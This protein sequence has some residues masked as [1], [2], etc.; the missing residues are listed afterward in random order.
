S[1]KTRVRRLR[2]YQVEA[3]ERLVAEPAGSSWPSGHPAVAAA[4]L[5]ALAPQ[6]PRATRTAGGVIAGFVATSRVYVGV[7]YP[8]DVVAGLGLGGMC[9]AAW[10]LA[11]RRYRRSRGMTS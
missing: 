3:A 11:T 10:R 5:T 6:L 2:P 7:H 9:G 4:V 1:L 8:T